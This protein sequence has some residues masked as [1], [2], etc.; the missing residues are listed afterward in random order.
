[1]VY[2]GVLQ[3]KIQPLQC[4]A[5]VVRP[6]LGAAA[7]LGRWFVGVAVLPVCG[8]FP[9]RRQHSATRA[10][11]PTSVWVATLRHAMGHYKVKCSLFNVQQE[12]WWSL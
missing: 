1:M 6:V 9:T 3:G 5:G 11:S 4:A 12:V 10:H 8:D 7:G 2:H